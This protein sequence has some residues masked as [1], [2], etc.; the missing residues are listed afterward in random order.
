QAD[1]QK[2]Y[3]DREKWAQMSLKNTANSGIFSADRAVLDYARD[4]WYASPVP[5]GK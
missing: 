2:L 5:M 4:I 1:L 3:G